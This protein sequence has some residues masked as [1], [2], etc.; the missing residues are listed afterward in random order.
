MTFLSTRSGSAASLLATSV[1]R[2]AQQMTLNMDNSCAGFAD[3]FIVLSADANSAYSRRDSGAQ[4]PIMQI[5]T[6]PGAALLALVLAAV[7]HTATAGP[8]DFGRAELAIAL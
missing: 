8:V 4:V 1:S 6:N 3:R 5:L 2:I 7:A